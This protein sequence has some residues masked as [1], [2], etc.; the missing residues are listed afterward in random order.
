MGTGG[1][2]AGLSVKLGDNATRHGSDLEGG[3]RGEGREA[4]GGRGGS[5][6]RW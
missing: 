3:G 1:L 6:V 5:E 4:G 2:S